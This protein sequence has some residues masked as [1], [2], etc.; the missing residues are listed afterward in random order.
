MQASKGKPMAL[1]I[2][3]PQ[4]HRIHSGFNEIGDK[5]C[6]YLSQANLNQLQT[7]NLG[8]P[9]GTQDITK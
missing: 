5:G 2:V 7:I 6:D 1:A 9:L 3:V 4:Y 8:T